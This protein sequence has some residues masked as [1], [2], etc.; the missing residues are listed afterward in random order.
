MVAAA[1]LILSALAPAQDDEGRRI[2]TDM[3]ATVIAHLPLPQATGSQM[4]LQRDNGKRL[5]VRAAGFEAGL[6]DR[7]CQQTRV[8]QPFEAQC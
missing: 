4:F 6:H 2:S 3:P 7:G 5:S 1:A 8:S